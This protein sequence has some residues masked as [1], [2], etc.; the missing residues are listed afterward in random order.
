MEITHTAQVTITCCWII[1]FVSGS[2]NLPSTQSRVDV[3]SSP[4]SKLLQ[5]E[6]E[7]QKPGLSHLAVIIKWAGW[8]GEM[9]FCVVTSTLN[10]S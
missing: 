6:T 2:T 10:N 7:I 5:G 9:H 3:V 1:C 8:D 4:D